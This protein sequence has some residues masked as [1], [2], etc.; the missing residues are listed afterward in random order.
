MWNLIGAG[1]AN[2]GGSI[3][4]NETNKDIARDATNANIATAREQM[5]FQERM[6]NTSHQRQVE[7]LKLAGLNPLLSSTGGAS[8]PA[9]AAGSAVT[10]EMENPLEGALATAKEAMSMQLQT[11]KQKEEIDLMR[12]QGKATDAQTHKTNVDAEVAKKGIP[13]AE[14]KNKLYEWMAKP[15]MDKARGVFDTSAKEVKEKSERPWSQ[16][17]REFFEKYD[18]KL[19]TRNKVNQIIHP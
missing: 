4:T 16:E 1:I 15:I 7:D 3:L 11:Q 13:A 8:S 5:A 19:K 2:L 18:P 10:A 6:S 12:K 9:G 17:E 14:I